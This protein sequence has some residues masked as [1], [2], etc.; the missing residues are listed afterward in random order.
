MTDMKC[1]SSSIKSVIIDELNDRKELF[2][3]FWLTRDECS[4]IVDRRSN[5]FMSVDELGSTFQF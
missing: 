2:R 3:L 1:E 4:R 5:M